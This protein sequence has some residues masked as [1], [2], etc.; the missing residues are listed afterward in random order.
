MLSFYTHRSRVPLF[1]SSVA[2]IH[3]SLD[4]LRRGLSCLLALRNLESTTLRH[5][6]GLGAEATLCLSNSPHLEY[7]SLAHLPRM[8][9]PA[10]GNLS[11]LSKLCSLDIEG[12]EVRGSVGAWV[13]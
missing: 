7:L 1:P 10:I 12:C 6:H 4:L 13:K 8:D 3:D 5:C 11:G 2:P 9:D